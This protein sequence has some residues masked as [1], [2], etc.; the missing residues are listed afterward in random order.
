MSAATMPPQL[1]D[2]GLFRVIEL[3]A[4]YHDLIDRYVRRRV[5]DSQDADRVVSRVFARMAADI[6]EMP[7]RPLPWLIA[8]ARHECAAIRLGGRTIRPRP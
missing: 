5:T 4:R 8:T 3:Q 2:S 7:D 6:A 1:D